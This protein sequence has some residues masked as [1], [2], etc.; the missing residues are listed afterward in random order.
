M[1]VGARPA[2]PLVGARWVNAATPDGVEL[3]NSCFAL[4]RATRGLGGAPLAPAPFDRCLSFQCEQT[5]PV[6]RARVGHYVLVVVTR[7]V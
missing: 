7:S 2:A 6:G 3:V 5:G 1:S 4:E